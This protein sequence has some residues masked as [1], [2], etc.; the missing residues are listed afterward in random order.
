MLE[1]M[2]IKAYDVSVGRALNLKITAKKLLDKLAKE[3]YVETRVKGDHHRFED[4]KGHK[5]TVP[6][7]RL[8]ET[9][10]PTTYHFIKLQA[11]WK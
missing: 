10:S 2:R 11:G 8:K 1:L 7:A 9:I 5:V 3:G 4:G 6:Y